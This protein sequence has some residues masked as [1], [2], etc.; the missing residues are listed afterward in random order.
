[1]ET[2]F[3]YTN[4]YEKDLRKLNPIDKKKIATKINRTAELFSTDKV[5]FKSLIYKPRIDLLNGLISSLYILRVD[6]KL[7]V[8]FTI[9]D[10]PLFDQILITLL[11]V[12]KTPDEFRKVIPQLV[13][14]LYQKEL[15]DYG[16]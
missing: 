15:V 6:R 16:E 2:V 13:E 10:D 3:N 5:A 14:S 12:A 4:S 1:M 7:R 8:F 11:R 9:D